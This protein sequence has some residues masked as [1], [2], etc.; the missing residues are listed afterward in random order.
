MQAGLRHKAD[1]QQ[2]YVSPFPCYIRLA[3]RNRVRIL[4]HIHIKADAHKLAVVADDNRVVVADGGGEQ[5]FGVIRVGGR[6]HFQAR[7]VRE[8]RVHR[9]RVLRRRVRSR[10]R[11]GHNGQRHFDFAAEHIVN[12]GGVVQYL[13]PAHAHKADV[14]QVDH[15]TQPG[16][17]RA[18]ARAHK[19]RLRDGGVADARRP[20]VPDEALSQAHRPAPSVL[21]LFPLAAAR[22]VLPHYDHRGIPLQLLPQRL[23]DRLYVRKPP[24]PRLRCHCLCSYRLCPS[25]P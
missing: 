12:L 13:I 7:I 23:V 3:K 5:P 4:R 20:K 2:R 1:A 19:A 22:D 8:Y 25:L 14:H 21:E 17:R 24:N 15:R 10:A 9:L 16:R 6:D 11:A 18:H